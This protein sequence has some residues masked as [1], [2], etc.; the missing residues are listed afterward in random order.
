MNFKFRA[1]S[2]KLKVQG[3]KLRFSAL[4]FTFCFLLFA[5]SCSIPSLE[6]PECSEAR[7]QVKRFY[8]IHLGNEMK[9]SAE[10]LQMR[11]QYLTA[12]LKQELEKQTGGET[13]Y[14]T[15]TDDYPKAF[16]AGECQAAAPGKTSFEVLLFWKD[17]T[18]SEQREI[19]VEMLKEDEKWLVNKVENKK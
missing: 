16:R 14:F 9:P 2:S 17:D 11:E 10:N 8:S 4:L 1:E 12:H 3:F 18:R 6:A 13:D 7:N 5:F 19:R 15:Q